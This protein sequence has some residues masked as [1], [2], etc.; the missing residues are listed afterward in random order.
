MTGVLLV[1]SLVI[2]RTDIVL[3]LAFFLAVAALFL[4]HRRRLVTKAQIAFGG[5][6][7]PL[8]GVEELEK[9]AP[10]IV[11]GEIH[12]ESEIPHAEEH[13]FEPSEESG[14]N[15][16]KG[17]GAESLDEK[18]PLETVP[19]HPEQVSEYL[20]ERGFASP[21]ESSNSAA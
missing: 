3:G 4:E 14:S 17:V 2:L 16:F 15:E 5:S 11:K 12:P 21:F 8:A 7:P 13:P 18:Q 10:A 19:P 1:A 6:K 9:P 20:Q